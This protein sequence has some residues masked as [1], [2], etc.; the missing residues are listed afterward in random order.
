[1]G[2]LNRLNNDINNA[3]LESPYFVN[4]FREVNKLTSSSEEKNKNGYKDYRFSNRYI[5]GGVVVNNNSNYNA[6]YNFDLGIN[7]D[8]NFKCVFE[9]FDGLSR[10]NLKHFIDSIIS[11]TNLL[12]EGNDLAKEL[13][14]VRSIRIVNT[15]IDYMFLYYLHK[16]FHGLERIELRNCIIKRDAD[17]SKIKCDIEL[18]YSTIEDISSF[19]NTE[20]SISLYMVDIKRI[21][22]CSINSSILH[23]NTIE[24][25]YYIPVKELFF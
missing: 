2:I 7:W 13:D 22:S 9:N 4:K 8:Y 23:I 21:T 24:K 11:S 20:S 1:M 12:V 6:F 3:L 10:D 17:F 16:Y 18:R 19:R 14:K 5:N 15:T 25:D